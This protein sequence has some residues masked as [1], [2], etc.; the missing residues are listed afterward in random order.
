MRVYVWICFL[1]SV[2]TLSGTLAVEGNQNASGSQTLAP[3]SSVDNGTLLSNKSKT[4]E[5]LDTDVKE[6]SPNEASKQSSSLLTSIHQ[7]VSTISVEPLARAQSISNTA[8]HINS[9]S[10]PNKGFVAHH[11]RQNVTAYPG[12]D[13]ND[14]V[15]ADDPATEKHDQRSG[16][17]KVQGNI[18]ILSCVLSVGILLTL[19]QLMRG[20]KRRRAL[21]KKQKLSS[22]ASGGSSPA[23]KVW[24]YPGPPSFKEV[25]NV[26]SSSQAENDIGE[27]NALATEV[28]NRELLKENRIETPSPQEKKIPSKRKPQ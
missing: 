20:R 25:I 22:P 8:E 21:R 19:F 16:L 17:T 12:E 26:P 9:K 5:T 2:L 24:D 14:T 18:I 11:P 15:V 1:F 13:L 28:I 10:V 4:N 23:R 27:L 3:F 7:E 6:E